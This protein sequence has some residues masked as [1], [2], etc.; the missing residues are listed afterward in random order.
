MYTW[1]PCTRM[2]LHRFHLLPWTATS[3]A[4]EEGAPQLQTQQQAGPWRVTILPERL[5][6]VAVIHHLDTM[7]H[8][9][10]WSSRNGRYLQHDL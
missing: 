5:V 4:V 3:M 10:A 7:L 1:L 2:L 8:N 6:S 9:A